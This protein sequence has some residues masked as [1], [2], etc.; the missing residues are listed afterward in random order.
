[1]AAHRRPASRDA[2]FGPWLPLSAEGVRVYSITPLELR[3]VFQ[4]I[5]AELLDFS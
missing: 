5:A 2:A 4:M 3:N 1:M